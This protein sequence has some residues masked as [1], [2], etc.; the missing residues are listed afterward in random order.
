M[1]KPAGVSASSNDKLSV[2]HVGKLASQGTPRLETDSLISKSR[3]PHRQGAN[4]ET[5]DN[6]AKSQF[7]ERLVDDTRLRTRA[8]QRAGFGHVLLN[9]TI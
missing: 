3:Q 8:P 2:A 7:P 1:A 5:Y 9:M 4:G 6:L